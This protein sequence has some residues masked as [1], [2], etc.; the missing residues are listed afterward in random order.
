MSAGAADDGELLSVVDIIDEALA[1]IAATDQAPS[2]DDEGEGDG[3]EAGR[4]VARGGATGPKSWEQWER[5]SRR[6]AQGEAYASCVIDFAWT[7]GG[8]LPGSSAQLERMYCFHDPATTEDK[9]MLD[10]VHA[11]TT[12]LWQDR[13][14]LA[15]GRPLSSIT[16]VNARYG[17]K[18]DPAAGLQQDR[19]KLSLV[20]KN[21]A[22]QQQWRSLPQSYLV[23]DLADDSVPPLDAEFSA[24]YE[25]VRRVLRAGEAFCQN[26]EFACSYS[27]SNARM[28]GTTKRD[29][30]EVEYEV[31][32]CTRKVP[33]D[34]R[35]GVD[36]PGGGA[37]A[38]EA[39]QRGNK[40]RTCGLR[41]NHCECKS[42]VLTD[43]TTWQN[44]RAAVLCIGL[45]EYKRLSGLP[46]AT[47][48]ARALCKKVNA[49][50]R[51]KAQLLADRPDL[52]TLRSGIRDFL[53]QPGLQKMPPE[54]VLVNISGHGM[55]KDGTVYVL[56]LNAEL[57]DCEPDKDFLSTRDIFEYCRK[58]LD[59]LVRQSSPPKEV[60]FV[61]LIDA[62]RDNE[63]VSNPATLASSL[64]PPKGSAPVKWALCF[65][66]SR[67]STA[68]DGPPGSHSPFVTEL[69]HE[70]SGIFAMDIPLKRG[71]EDACRRMCEQHQG[72][73][74]M[75]MGLQT[76]KE[77]WCLCPAPFPGA[78]VGTESMPTTPSS[79]VTRVCKGTCGECGKGVYSDEARRKEGSQYYHERCSAPSAEFAWQSF[80][81]DDQDAVSAEENE[82]S[83]RTMHSATPAP[84]APVMSVAQIKAELRSR[85]VPEREIATCTE[86]RE[87]EDLLNA[88]L[89]STSDG[90]SSVEA[91]QHR[92]EQQEM[93]QMLKQQQITLESLPN[94]VLTDQDAGPQEVISQFMISEAM[95]AFA[96]GAAEASKYI[97]R[98][99][100]RSD[101]SSCKLCLKKKPAHHGPE[102]YCIAEADW[103]CQHCGRAKK[104]HHGD[105]VYCIHEAE[106]TCKI[107]AKT[108]RLHT[109]AGQY[110]PYDRVAADAFL[111]DLPTL[112]QRRSVSSIV[113]G[114]QDNVAHRRVQEQA[115]AVLLQ[116]TP[117]VESAEWRRI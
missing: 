89:I 1:T 108:R 24:R 45:G 54:T 75:L 52:I 32:A 88:L 68:S 87:L 23:W 17:R 115:C 69:L 48:D 57:N 58:D 44:L 91:A 42:E 26:V 67:D 2:P 12:E 38:N 114:M 82:A 22:L 70:D 28:R 47:R 79:P 111:R 104:E 61:F 37:Q 81:D 100:L 93:D 74:P 10:V 35:V 21:S 92:S 63:M 53:R 86:R 19:S 98:G 29:G 64:E 43:P 117:D 9:R 76:I 112:Q 18:I 51:C 83:P 72:Q 25:S 99:L 97:S 85:G 103:K 101:S 60:S 39:H 113:K 5:F 27:E 55:Q 78:A 36:A 59:M 80:K 50:P 16:S 107:C 105:K 73:T 56:P 110:C 4:G 106:Q 13:K 49:L 34:L 14:M 7:D 3:A 96:H 84:S 20:P 77:D 33:K 30:Q 62:C 11:H 95:T 94:A 31:V 116:L 66:C 46:N 109:G 102:F 71:L 6:V 8:R 15:V 41:F 40:C 65:S 90:S